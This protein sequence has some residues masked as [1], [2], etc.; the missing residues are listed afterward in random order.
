LV[1]GLLLLL[2]PIHWEWFLCAD[3][4]SQQQPEYSQPFTHGENVSQISVLG[5]TGGES[6]A[7]MKELWPFI[8]AVG[9]HWWALM[10]CAI[11]TG[12]G[13]FIAWGNKSN[14]WAVEASFA[15]AVICV[16]IACYLA[17]RDE[18]KLFIAEKERNQR[19]DIEGELFDAFIGE[20]T[21]S[22]EC[23][24]S[25]VVL[26]G[27][28]AWNKV[29]MPDVTAYRYELTI[30]VGE[31]DFAKSFT[32]TQKGWRVLLYN[33]L[34]I[35][36]IE[37]GREGMREIH[38]LNAYAVPSLIG[39]YVDGMPPTTSFASLVELTLI[40]LAGGRHPIRKSSVTFV[41]QL[42]GMPSNSLM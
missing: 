2:A 36:N 5:A 40:D 6:I 23:E 24:K 18:H 14:A 11:F 20:V 8:R 21:F 17:W 31:G 35:K 34:S 37:I 19:P 10:S 41:S 4:S 30:T 27:V 22:P 25:S 29:Q 39:F 26:F 13:V 9:K 32:G 16:F 1:L 3:W 12:L 7:G 15:A 28:K 38:Y 42:K 33:G